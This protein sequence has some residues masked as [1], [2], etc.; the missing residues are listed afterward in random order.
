MRALP[1]ADRN[2]NRMENEEQERER[3]R[4]SDV[5]R[6]AGVSTSTVS[7]ALSGHWMVNAQTRERIRKIAEEM[8]FHRDAAVSRVMQ[9]RRRQKPDSGLEILAVISQSAEMS[10]G[11][12]IQGAT[13]L[14]NV[15]RHARFQGFRLEELIVGQGGLTPAS[16]QKQLRARG[17]Q[18]CVLTTA[19][20]PEMRID[21]D[22]SAL[23]VAAMGLDY[24]HPIMHRAAS[25]RYDQVFLAVERLE[26]LGYRRIGLALLDF[27]LQRER[28]RWLAGYYAAMDERPREERLPPIR[29]GPAYDAGYLPA[30]QG[31]YKKYQPEAILGVDSTFLDFAEQAGLQVPRDFAYAALHTNYRPREGLAGV[32]HQ[33]ERVLKAVIDLVT[34]QLLRGEKGS[35]AWPKTVRIPSRWQDGMTAPGVPRN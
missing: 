3:V 22:I 2:R 31:W 33:R 4:L 25:D 19:P 12:A 15:R 7:R 11:A 20:E 1:G 29:F 6:A 14:D 5:A 16:I 24:A 27:G 9:L 21:F 17:I 35:P 30:F 13:D 34:A 23:S 28:R 18:G 10:L 26:A 8:G 32:D